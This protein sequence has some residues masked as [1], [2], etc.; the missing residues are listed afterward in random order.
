MQSP[1]KHYYKNGQRDCAEKNE[2]PE[3]G[4]KDMHLRGSQQLRNIVIEDYC[5]N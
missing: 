4:G 2:V 5:K 1:K 3:I